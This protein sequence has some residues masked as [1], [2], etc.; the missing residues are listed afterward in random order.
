MGLFNYSD[1]IQKYTSNVRLERSWSAHSIISNSSDYLF[2]P[3]KSRFI[4]ISEILSS[5]YE[6]KLVSYVRTHDHVLPVEQFDERFSILNA[7]ASSHYHD[8]SIMKLLLNIDINYM[9]E[10][11]WVERNTIAHPAITPSDVSIDMSSYFRHSIR[12]YDDVRREIYVDI[13]KSY[14]SLF[15]PD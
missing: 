6:E 13:C 15:I 8:K 12:P 4:D 11:Y 7:I 3:A 14:I 9:K 1:L 5:L 2:S 10:G